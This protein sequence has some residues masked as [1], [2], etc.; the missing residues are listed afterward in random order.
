VPKAEDRR[1]IRDVRVLAAL[2]HPVRTALLSHLM[3]VGPRTASECARAVDASPS[4]CSWHLRHLARFGLVERV[5][6]GSGGRDADGRE[7]PWRATATGFSFTPAADPAGRA[8]RQALASVQ[9]EESDRL[10]RGYL[11][12]ED[13]VP[14][15]W[16]EAAALSSYGLLL[17]AGE[18]R[19]LTER[20]DALIRPYIAMTREQAPPGARPVH[21]ALTAFLRP[22]EV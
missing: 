20:L 18:L 16:R 22:E 6:A 11:R 12:G 4:N 13:D 14:E 15:E 17:D 1:E 21:L 5:E 19:E 7:R 3:A 2:A 10:A 9:L 8:A